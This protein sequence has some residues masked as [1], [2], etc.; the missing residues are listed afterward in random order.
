MA[1]MAINELEPSVEEFCIVTEM[2]TMIDDE[3]YFDSACNEPH[4][5]FKGH[6][7]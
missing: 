5:T 2:D 4:D 3:W 1:L 6:S 7:Q